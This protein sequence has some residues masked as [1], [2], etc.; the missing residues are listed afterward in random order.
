METARGSTV[1]EREITH[2][3]LLRLTSTLVPALAI[4]ATA[5]GRNAQHA[6]IKAASLVASQRHSL[7]IKSACCLPTRHRYHT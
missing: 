3:H 2:F 6:L 4:N 7:E 5:G 1:K